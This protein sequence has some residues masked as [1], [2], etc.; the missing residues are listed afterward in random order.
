[1]QKYIEKYI[2]EVCYVIAKVRSKVFPFENYY[3]GFWLNPDREQLELISE[4][5]REFAALGWIEPTLRYGSERRQRDLGNYLLNK[6]FESFGR[7]WNELTS[8]DRFSDITFNPSE[9]EPTIAGFCRNCC[10]CLLLPYE[11]LQY[12]KLNVKTWKEKIESLGGEVNYVCEA[13]LLL[14]GWNKPDLNAVKKLQTSFHELKNHFYLCEYK[15]ALRLLNKI[16]DHARR[17]DC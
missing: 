5:I 17:C 9:Q 11:L 16:S 7:R 12:P 3:D 6:N 15:D 14:L 4:V 10:Y 2:D 8:Y 13:P 1:M